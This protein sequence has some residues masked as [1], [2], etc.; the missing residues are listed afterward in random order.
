MT[1]PPDRPDLRAVPYAPGQLDISG[2]DLSPAE[3]AAADEAFRAELDRIRAARTE[4]AV[5]AVSR[6]ATA[7]ANFDAAAAELDA[8]VADARNAGATW[9]QIGRAAGMTR[10][11]AWERWAATS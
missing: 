10:Q 2:R 7:V 11:S 1:Q 5:R 8:A 4:Y 9:E 3:L 6:V